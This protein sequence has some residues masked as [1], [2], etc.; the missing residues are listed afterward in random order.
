MSYQYIFR[1]YGDEDRSQPTNIAAVME[2]KL[3][4]KLESL[5]I[6]CLCLSQASLVPLES[7]CEYLSD[8][9][10][11]VLKYIFSSVIRR[12]FFTYKTI[13]K[14]LDPSY[15]TDLDYQD[16]LE[17]KMPLTLEFQKTG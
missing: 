2:G 13:P 6:G 5:G 17:G 4:E 7:V 3:K 10:L 16:C 1:K 15:K 14:H 9:P 11:V 8:F 12:N